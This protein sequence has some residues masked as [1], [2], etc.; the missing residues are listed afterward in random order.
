MTVASRTTASPAPSRRSP[1]RSTTRLPAWLAPQGPHCDSPGAEQGQ[2]RTP[3]ALCEHGDRT[4]GGREQGARRSRPGGPRPGR[5]SRRPAARS[6][7]RRRPGRAEAPALDPPTPSPQPAGVARAGVTGAGR[8][9]A[10]QG[11]PTGDGG[12]AQPSGTSVQRCQS[13]V[14][15]RCPASAHRRPQPPPDRAPLAPLAPLAP[16][17]PG[18]RGRPGGRGCRDGISRAAWRPPSRTRACAAA[19]AEGG[20]TARIGRRPA[21]GT[22]QRAGPRR[23]TPRRAPLPPSRPVPDAARDGGS[24]DPC[25]VQAR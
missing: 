20:H 6:P 4:A 1:A 24:W 12:G 16:P 23:R 15:A 10:G 9:G 8:H 7:R 22:G 18:R 5:P 11:V 3:P 21:S 25:Q 17:N 14:P 13:H 19:G 2:L